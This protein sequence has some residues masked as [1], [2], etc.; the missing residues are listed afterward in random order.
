MQTGKE[1]ARKDGKLLFVDQELIGQKF[2]GKPDFEELL[3]G[4][5]ASVEANSDHHVIYYTLYYILNH[6]YSNLVIPPLMCLLEHHELECKQAGL[7]L[8]YLLFNKEV[9]FSNR[10]NLKLFIPV[11]KQLNA[12]YLK[13]SFD[14]LALIDKREFYTQI[15]VFLGYYDK[16][17]FLFQLIRDH[18]DVYHYHLYSELYCDTIISQPPNEFY[19]D[20]LCELYCTCPLLDQSLLLIYCANSFKMDKKQK[21]AVAHRMKV[22]IK[23]SL[24][25]KTFDAEYP[26]INALERVENIESHIPNLNDKE[27]HYLMSSLVQS[28][29][30][31]SN[32]YIIPGL[33]ACYRLHLAVSFHILQSKSGKQKLCVS[34]F[35]S[36]IAV[37]KLS[38]EILKI[39]LEDQVLEI[40]GVPWMEYLDENKW[41]PAPGPAFQK[42]IIENMSIR[43]CAKVPLPETDEISL[44]L[45][46][47]DGKRYTVNLPWICESNQKRISMCNLKIINQRLESSFF[48]SPKMKFDIHTPKTFGVLLFDGF[49]PLDVFGPIQFFTNLSKK[50]PVEM[51]F[52]SK[53]GQP[54]NYDGKTQNIKVQHSFENTPKLDLFMVP[55]GMGTRQLVNEPETKEFVLKHCKESQIVFSVCTGSALL[56]SSGFLNNRKATS[57][58]KAWKWVTSVSD[59]VDW[60]HQARWVEDG[61]LITSSGVA[62]GMDAANFVIKK[63]YSQETSSEIAD[64]IEYEPQEDAAVDHFAAVFP[65][66]SIN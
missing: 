17:D 43:D 40:N 30:G 36:N 13:D 11:L 57:N 50:F 27:F 47:R 24:N 22:Q 54:V 14:L 2:N 10:I 37:L 5:K 62:A 25:R 34:R 56:A 19:L 6:Y 45:K 55:G 15:S 16:L 60:V 41:V 49:A 28:V 48:K 12:F 23:N 66:E 20:F 58:K 7:N 35:S 31:L 21:K 18:K 8:L 4:L 29:K 9:K 65:L 51:V 32:I 33:H 53:D 44:L 26:N 64:A 42:S 46:R 61:D 1:F 52:I 38:P 3:L 63:Y 39:N 59:K